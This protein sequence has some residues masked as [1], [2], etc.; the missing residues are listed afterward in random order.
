[1]VPV[2]RVQNRLR[3]CYYKIYQS[4][5]LRRL[6]F[7]IYGLVYLLTILSRSLSNSVY[8]NKGVAGVGQLSS[9]LASARYKN[10]KRVPLS[11]LPKR[12]KEEP[13]QR[14]NRHKHYLGQLASLLLLFL[15]PLFT[16][17]LVPGTLLLNYQAYLL[18]L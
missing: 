4:G 1:M 5:V 14:I 7:A 9:L 13:D 11:N 18:Y 10:F 16:T 12:D 2:A 17:Y 3:D 8:L 6:D 15:K